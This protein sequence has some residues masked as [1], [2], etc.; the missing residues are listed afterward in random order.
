MQA[1]NTVV[2]GEQHNGTPCHFYVYFL[3]LVGGS[4]PPKRLGYLSSSDLMVG[5]LKLDTA[6]APYVELVTQIYGIQARIDTGI[7][8]TSVVGAE[9]KA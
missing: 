1:Y 8:V 9:F 5:Q 4:R 7:T 2:W 6:Q 3:V